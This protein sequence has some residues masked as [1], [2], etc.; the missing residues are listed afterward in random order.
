MV[1]K[2]TRE[3]FPPY[4]Y[5]RSWKNPAQPSQPHMETSCSPPAMWP[6]DSSW[7]CVRGPAGS[8]SF[9]TF[10]GGG[11]RRT[12]VSRLEHFAL[13]LWVLPWEDPG[14]I[15]D[16]QRN[17]VSGGQ[18][19]LPHLW[20]TWGLRCCL[21]HSPANHL[22]VKLEG[23]SVTGSPGGDRWP[24]GAPGGAV[25]VWEGGRDLPWAFASHHLETISF[26]SWPV[27]ELM[28]GRRFLGMID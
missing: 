10:R 23:E 12:G 21:S 26:C 22:S 3:C 24:P 1:L 5:R 8:T 11:G 27:E 6:P 28:R 25:C 17:R 15:W 16:G 7:V 14:S 9:C 20:V 19:E 13:C 4:G 2:W 18:W